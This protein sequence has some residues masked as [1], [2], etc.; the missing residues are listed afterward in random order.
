MTAMTVEA[1]L[2]TLSAKGIAVKSLP[3]SAL[4]RPKLTRYSGA[5]PYLRFWFRF[6]RPSLP[7]IERG[8]GDAVLDLVKPAPGA[9]TSRHLLGV[10]RPS[11]LFW[12]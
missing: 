1:A 9:S 2:E 7:V 4:A 3:Y 12:R 10:D 6:V 5:D 8:R 11:M